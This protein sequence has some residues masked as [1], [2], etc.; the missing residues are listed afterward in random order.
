MS[1]SPIRVL[2]S[3]SSF[4][5]ENPKPIARLKREG[6]EYVLNPYGRTLMEHEVDDLL[7]GMEGLIAGTEPLTEAVL[8]RAKLLKVVSRVGSGLDNVDLAAAKRLGIAIF[9]T[10]EAPVDAV[11]ELTLAGI[12]AVLRK[13]HLMHQA[14]RDGRWE[15]RMGSLLTGKTVGIVGLGRIGKRLAELLEPFQVRILAY[16]IRPPENW[17]GQRGIA[18]VSL[19]DLLMEAHVVSLHVSREPGKGYLLG[20]K[21]IALLKPGAVLVNTARGGL[22]DEKAL[23]HALQQGALAGIFL[24]TFEQEPYSGPLVQIPNVLLTPH[25]G[26][27]AQETRSRME[28]EAVEN[29]LSA[30]NKNTKGKK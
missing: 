13:V 25:V 20:E 12:L 29:L 1:G 9:A 22:V 15:K 7:N 17:A 19:E 28:M 10:P 6:I 26:S 23:A 3:T 14:I 5:Q 11:A 18:M 2:I 27:Y 4:A 16:D 8:N 30:I 24:D 21:E